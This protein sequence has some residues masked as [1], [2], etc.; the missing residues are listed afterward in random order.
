MEV[1]IKKELQNLDRNNFMAVV[2]L[3]DK[4]VSDLSGLLIYVGDETMLEATKDYMIDL[5][6]PDLLDFDT[7]LK[8]SI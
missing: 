8:D 6:N 5:I 2:N 4:I 7:T 3:V 1:D